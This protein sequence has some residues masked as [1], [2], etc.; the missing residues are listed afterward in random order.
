MITIYEYRITS[1][2]YL[3]GKIYYTAE[4]ML[5]NNQE[6]YSLNKE[7]PKETKEKCLEIIQKRKRELISVSLLQPK[8][9]YL[10]NE[11]LIIP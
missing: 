10:P 2:R 11:K 9:E 7:D 5:N 3:D 6:W 8:Y 1:K 4:E